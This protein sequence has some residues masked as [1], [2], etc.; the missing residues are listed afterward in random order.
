MKKTLLAFAIPALLAAGTAT[1]QSRAPVQDNGFY[2]NYGQLGYLNQDWDGG[3]DVDAVDGRLSYALDQQLFLR[4]EMAFFDGDVKAG[5]AGEID[6]D[7]WWLAAGLGFHTPLQRNVDLVLTGDIVRIDYEVEDSFEDD[8]VG[9]ALSVGARGRS[10]DKLELY[11][12]L[13]AQDIDENEFGFFGEL[14][15]HASQQL[16]VGADLKLGDDLTQIG[17]F[18]RLNF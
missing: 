8:D 1:A 9:F 2:Y 11:G 17:L 5:K 12:G 6:V 7:G 15:V 13:F 16:D 3:F 4:G 14:L 10:G 18:A